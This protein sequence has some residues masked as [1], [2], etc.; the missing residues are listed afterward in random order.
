VWSSRG[1]RLARHAR[2][3]FV[4]DADE[5]NAFSKLYRYERRQSGVS[6][7]ALQ[8]L[9]HTPDHLMYR[10]QGPAV[11]GDRRGLL[12]CFR[13]RIF[14]KWLCFV[15]KVLSS[16]SATTLLV[17]TKRYRNQGLCHLGSYRPDP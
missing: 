3:A 15:K 5:A 6:N 2:P 13:R 4:R 8:E 9:R 16:P 12:W 7:K 1:N 14:E 17:A 11:R 10:G